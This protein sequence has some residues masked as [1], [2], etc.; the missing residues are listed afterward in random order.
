M[1]WRLI[2]LSGGTICLAGGMGGSVRPLAT[3]EALQGRPQRGH[4]ERRG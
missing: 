1:D 3:A 4:E 2:G